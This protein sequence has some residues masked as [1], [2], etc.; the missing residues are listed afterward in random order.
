M[1]SLL[2]DDSGLLGLD[3]LAPL[4]LQTLL[5]AF[6]LVALIQTTLEHVE[7]VEH[8][9]FK[10]L[11]MILAALRWLRK[12]WFMEIMTLMEPCCHKLR[13]IY[14]TVPGYVGFVDLSPKLPMPV[15][16][17]VEC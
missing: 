8:V 13:D 7:H 6:P 4:W 2:W 1:L 3:A 10:R 9:H 11:S 17:E 5:Y 12:A 16:S 15:T 14:D